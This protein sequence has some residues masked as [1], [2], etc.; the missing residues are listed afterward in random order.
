MAPTRRTSAT[1]T[2]RASLD[3]GTPAGK[4]LVRA[5]LQSDP[6]QQKPSGRN[7][8]ETAGMLFPSDIKDA[9]RRSDRRI[10][11]SRLS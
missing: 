11:L 5:Q 3:Q 9:S 1:P 6:D 8:H 7:E 10:H 4:M 2:G